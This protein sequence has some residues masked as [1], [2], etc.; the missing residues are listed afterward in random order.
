MKRKAH[1]AVTCGL[2]A[3]LAGSAWVWGGGQTGQP[4][5]ADAD[6]S[7]DRAAVQAATQQFA[8]AFESGDATALAALFTET[9][10]YHDDD[11]GTV[12]GRAALAKAYGEFFAG[13]AELKAEAKSNAVRFLGKDT[14]VEEGTLTVKA[15][16][17]PSRAAR[18]S[19]LYARQDGKW[20]LA[21]LK[22]W[23]DDAT[24]RAN[25]NDLAWLIGHWESAS[26]DVTARTTYEWAPSKAFII[27]RYTITPKAGEQPRVGT[28]VIGVDPA[29][30]SIRSWTFDAD[31]AIGEATWAWEDGRWAIDSE[32]TLPD[33]SATT[34]R[35]F[36]TKVGN[37]LFT[38]KSV[39][40]MT[41]G[42]EQPDVGPVTVKRV[43]VR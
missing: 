38:W 43:A 13:R 22:E 30:G 39:K 35:N 19:A 28:Q 10:E 29:F 18:F 27:A 20:L 15:K 11:G 41:D 3:L 33:G 7:A 8:R 42:E 6:R 40:R 37:D 21:M 24:E 4:P 23:G 25:L 16:D 36:L 31:G 5:A 2:L 26:G 17:Q 32:G 12:R 9:G 14:A 1:L 34:A